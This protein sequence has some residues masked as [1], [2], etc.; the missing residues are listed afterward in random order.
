VDG[1]TNGVYVDNSVTH[2][3]TS[4]TDPWWK[5]DLEKVYKV[6]RIVVHNRSDCCSERIIGFVVEVYQGEI[7]DSNRVYSSSTLDITAKNQSVYKFDLSTMN[8]SGDI[9][10]ITIPGGWKI[11]S[12][13]EVLVYSDEVDANP[14]VP[15][16][17]L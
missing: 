9:V 4:E 14:R 6:E 15:P 7:S 17:C 5:V 12:L 8:V 11:L 1:N 10:M 13:A 3:A 16:L 2:T